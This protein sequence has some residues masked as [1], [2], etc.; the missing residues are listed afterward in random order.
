MSEHDIT[1]LLNRWGSGDRQALDELMPLIY[2]ELK[3]IAGSYLRNERE[4]HTLQ[5]TALVNEA[6]MRLT[7]YHESQPENRKHFFTIA[8]QAMRRVLVDHARKRKA[9]KRNYHLMLPETGVEI[10]GADLEFDLV[11]LDGALEQLGAFDP[12]KARIVELRFF[13]G[14]SVPE[15]AEMLDLSTATVKREWSVARAWL[16]RALNGEVPADGSATLG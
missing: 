8:A 5:P 12:R 14:L 16:Y 9:V 4:G 6:Y 11:A 7:Q 13:G 1:I 2:S 15:S 10:G 3:R